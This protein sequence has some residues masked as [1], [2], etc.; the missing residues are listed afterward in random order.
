MLVELPK[1]AVL[2]MSPQQ[3]RILSSAEAQDFLETVEAHEAAADLEYFKQLSEVLASK[4]KEL[5]QY[6][7]IMERISEER[8][9]KLGT[10]EHTLEL[11]ERE[12]TLLGLCIDLES[13]GNP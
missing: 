12:C 4:V 9:S 11:L 13:K 7:K 2:D 1:S 3:D 10:L 8:E 6:I 5:A